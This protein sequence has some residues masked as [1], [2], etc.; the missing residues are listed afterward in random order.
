[1]GH[2]L[3][4]QSGLLHNCTGQMDRSCIIS[5][6]HSHKVGFNGLLL[7][8]PKSFDIGCRGHCRETYCVRKWMERDLNKRRMKIAGC[9]S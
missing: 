8:D 6:R 7:P 2:F 9:A 5:I 4:G 3:L 1:M